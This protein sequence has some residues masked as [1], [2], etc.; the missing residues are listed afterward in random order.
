MEATE[1]NGEEWIDLKARAMAAGFT[2]SV[3]YLSYTADDKL[4]VQQLIALQLSQGTTTAQIPVTSY[5]TSDAE[6]LHFNSTNRIHVK[7]AFTGA[8]LDQTRSAPANWGEPN[9]SETILYP[10]W[11]YN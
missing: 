1:V 2:S 5:R 4:L 8:S 3:E 7:D 9:V 11:E 6:L 10:P